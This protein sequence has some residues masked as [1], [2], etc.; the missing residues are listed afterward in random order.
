M[1]LIEVKEL[2]TVLTKQL[3]EVWD[4]SVRE[5]HLFL[6]DSEIKDISRYIPQALSSIAHLIVAFN[7]ENNP[8]AFMGIEDR[9]LEMLFVSPGYRGK[10]LGKQLIHYGIE[11]YSINEL[12]VNEQN[13][14]AKAF[15]EHMGFQVYKRT[16][17]DE[18]GNPYPILY[19]RLV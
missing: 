5:T 1:K 16:D 14:Q 10:G 9:K 3:F 2:N 4:K 15:Y 19:M 12:G 18:Q 11:N 7:D 13:P 17:T 8:V 6:S